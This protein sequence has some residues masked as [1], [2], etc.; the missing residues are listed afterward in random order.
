MRLKT[1]P[2]FQDRQW[3]LLS[4]LRRL[5]QVGLK[6]ELSHRWP[7]CRLGSGFVIAYFLLMNMSWTFCSLRV[8]LSL[9]YKKKTLQVEDLLVSSSSCLIISKA[10]ADY[11]HLSDLP[12]QH[13]LLHTL[14]IV[15]PLPS[16]GGT[17][18][19]PQSTTMS[20]SDFDA[21]LSAEKTADIS[22]PE[23]GSLSGKEESDMP[24]LES[25]TPAF[26]P[27]RGFLLA[28]ASI[29]II[30]LAA[31]L[32][33]TSLSIALPIITVKLKGTAIEAFWSGTSF[34]LTSAVFQPVIAGLSHVFGRKQ[35][36][37]TLSEDREC[38]LIE[39]SWFSHRPSSSLS[40]PF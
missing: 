13:L 14:L 6:V 7:K 40:A 12:H 27:T 19:H 37:L 39:Y 17:S 5:F 8:D 34:L 20:G 36:S 11:F 21:P 29:C 25:V 28:F 31:A 15:F 18:L 26:Q 30:T 22:S 16:T 33:A 35:V 3:C 38:C 9:L 10:E 2:L 1:A 23:N 4:T 24:A 32:D